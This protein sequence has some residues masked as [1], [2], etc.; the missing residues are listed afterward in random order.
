MINLLKVAGLSLGLCL[1][2]HTAFAAGDTAI[3]DRQSWSFSGVFGRYDNNQLQRGFQV[4]QNVCSACHTMSQVSFRNLSEKGGPEFKPEQIKE[5]AAKWPIQV[6]DG[7][8]DKGEMF[9]RPARPSDKFPSPHANTEAAKVANGGA[10]PPDFSVLAK[11]R[12]YR[13]GFPGFIID[14]L[15]GFTY[16]ES[17]PDYIYALIAKGYLKDGETPPIKVE[18]GL[19]YNTYMPGQKIAMAAPLAD[20]QVEYTDG[21]PQTKEQYSRDV[22]A[23]MMWA[24][25]PHL[26]QRKQIGFRVMLF[27][28]VFAGLLYFTKKKVWAD[29]KGKGATVGHAH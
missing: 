11:A 12:S 1:A 20:G 19:N 29:V 9:E 17:G 14:A 26:E 4:Y 7:P 8:N 25:E 10:L 3:P 16:Q 27:L 24:A 28:I 22:V 13:I 18:D 2:S 15:P 23:F 21:S 6:K 5:L